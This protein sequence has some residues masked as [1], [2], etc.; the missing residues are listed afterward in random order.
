MN[1]SSKLKQ[2]YGVFFGFPYLGWQR[3]KE[4]FSKHESLLSVDESSDS[5]A[6][7]VVDDASS[8]RDNDDR[9]LD[10]DRDH[11][12]WEVDQEESAVMKL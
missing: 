8:Q 11:V 2:K 12:D 4:Q 10:Q 9:D 1:K 3:Y 7:L 6:R 5:V